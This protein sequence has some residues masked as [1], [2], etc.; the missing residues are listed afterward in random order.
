MKWMW[1]TVLEVK[2]RQLDEM[3]HTLLSDALIPLHLR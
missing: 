1:A 3:L 2:V